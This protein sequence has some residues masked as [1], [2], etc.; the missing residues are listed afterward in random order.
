MDRREIVVGVSGS[1]ASGLA[2]R[3]AAEEAR[4]RGAPL[5]IVHTWEV[6]SGE[7]MVAGT[8]FREATEKEALERAMHWVETALGTQ[9]VPGTV[10]IVEGP[11]AAVL[12]GRSRHAALL[13][14]GTQE[15][16]GLHRLITGSVSH[17]CVSHATCPVVAI[18]AP[19]LVHRFPPP[20]EERSP[21]PGP[22]GQP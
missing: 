15:S 13:V 14:V 1:P 18:P 12:V 22:L 3:W 6:P 20:R 5:R 10:D 8:A 19:A 17:F 16:R 2:L 11:A 21:V 9:D 4:L 7:A